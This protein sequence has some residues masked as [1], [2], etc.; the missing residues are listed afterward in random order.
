MDTSESSRER[1]TFLP[2]VIVIVVFFLG[3]AGTAIA[4]GLIVGPS[5]TTNESGTVR[6]VVRQWSVGTTPSA[7]AGDVTFVVTNTGSMPH[8]LLVLKT[9]VRAGKLPITDA[10]DPPVPVTS[11]ADKVSEDDL[12]GESGEP[13]IEPGETRR[14]TIENMEPGKYVLL[15]NIAGHYG[16][17]M[18]AAFTVTA[19]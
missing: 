16:N 2:I 11:G 8:E 3:L 5:G 14:F 4:L 1:S 6:V 12:V 10:G 13:D 17:G 19:S 15:C 7:P 9:D 18:R